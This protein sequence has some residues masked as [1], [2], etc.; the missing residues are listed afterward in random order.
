MKLI[1]IVALGI[2]MAGAGSAVAQSTF[3]GNGM[4]LEGYA[5]AGAYDLGLGYTTAFYRID[6][7]TGMRPADGLGFGFNLGAETVGD[8]VHRDA[9]LYP[10]I[11]Y[12]TG[13]GTF[14][15]GLPRFLMD[16][17]YLPEYHFA[18]TSFVDL[19]YRPIFGSLAGTAYLFG[20]GNAP[21]G[22]RYDGV[23]G[24]T[25]VGAS[26]HH[27]DSGDLEVYSAAFRRELG[28]IGSF[29]DVAF[30]GGVEYL[31]AT[32]IDFKNYRVGAQ[33]TRDKLTL[34]ALYG[35]VDFSPNLR[36]GV[37]FADYQVNRKLTVNG[38]W[39]HLGSTSFSE[40]L[41]GLG[42]EYRFAHDKAYAKASVLRSDASGSDT[43]L[44]ASVGY[45]F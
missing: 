43:V 22:V 39:A 40:N 21:Y 24:K 41:L 16:R 14:S 45:R 19:D 36:G 44:E 26:Y 11:S 8:D 35:N 12:G 38:H 18:N 4:Y 23:F 1:G 31:K 37:V 9:A 42:V 6:I 13:I 17:G 7:D 20:A 32:T 10:T 33:G 5:T 25:S 2:G 29:E 28:K 27:F 3:S 30:F 15:V 34:G